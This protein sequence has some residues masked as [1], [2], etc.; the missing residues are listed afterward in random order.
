M[1]RLV[2]YQKYLTHLLYH[3]THIQR[4]HL[5][6]PCS[7]YHHLAYCLLHDR[8]LAPIIRLPHRS[9]PVDFY[10]KRLANPHHCPINSHFPNL[11]SRPVKSSWYVALW[12]TREMINS[13]Y[14]NINL[15]LNDQTW[16]SQSSTS[17]AHCSKPIKWMAHALHKQRKRLWSATMRNE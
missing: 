9:E 4:V 11:E 14:A 15:H 8:L 17:T 7:Q 3:R 16:T 12:I 5:S 13:Q 1:L 6:N 2:Q 10:S